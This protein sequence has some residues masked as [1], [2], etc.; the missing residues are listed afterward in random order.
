VE[1]EVK[2]K[3]RASAA[4][5]KSARTYLGLEQEELARA[6]GISRPTLS[7]LEAGNAVS[8]ESTREAVQTALEHRGI[9]FTN[10]DSPGFRYEEK[11]AIIPR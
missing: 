10:G 3:V 9:V 2:Q 5:L 7:K 11:K 1:S 8:F 4:L 6:A